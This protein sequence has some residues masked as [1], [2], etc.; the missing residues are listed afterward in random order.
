MASEIC[1]GGGNDVDI[2]SGLSGC[3]ALQ[4]QCASFA[5]FPKLPKTMMDNF[6]KVGPAILGLIAR[7]NLQGSK[8]CKGSN[9]ASSSDFSVRI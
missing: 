5:W 2:V 4:L 8:G 9:L 3:S 6:A 7:L 1:A